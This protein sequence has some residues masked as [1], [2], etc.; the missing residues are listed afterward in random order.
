MGLEFL[1]LAYNWVKKRKRGE[2][3]QRGKFYLLVDPGRIELPLAQCECAVIPLNY[4]PYSTVTDL[5][6]FLGLSTSQP[7]RTLQ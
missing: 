5:A 4:G 6:K 1:F 7:T 2:I 3:A